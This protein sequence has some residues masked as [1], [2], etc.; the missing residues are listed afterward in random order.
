MNM[1][2]VSNHGILKTSFIS[3][4]FKYAPLEE[5]FI[6]HLFSFNCENIVLYMEKFTE[7]RKVVSIFL[8]IDKVP[9]FSENDNCV[10]RISH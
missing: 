6:N 5:T 1:S 2:T 4:H 7:T 3:Y 9:R 10:P 8:E